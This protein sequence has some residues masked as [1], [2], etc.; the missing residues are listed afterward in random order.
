MYLAIAIAVL[1]FML[2]PIIWIVPTPSQKRQ[3]RLRERA[4]QLGLEVRVVTLPQTRRA[5]ARREAERQIL[6]YTLP[7]T[8]PARSD[9]WHYWLME[10]EPEDNTAPGDMAQ[11][12]NDC[13]QQWPKGTALVEGSPRGL[14]V[15][16]RESGADVPEVE[17]LAHLLTSLVKELH[18]EQA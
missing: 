9:H 8:K 1:A 3:A 5:R 2:A 11:R 10:S 13:R 4:R 14:S 16:W 15:Y 18:L 17:A 7:L 12:M 6:R